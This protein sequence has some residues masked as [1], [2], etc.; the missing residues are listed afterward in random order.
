MASSSAATGVASEDFKLIVSTIEGIQEATQKLRSRINAGDIP[1]FNLVEIRHLDVPGQATRTSLLPD[2]LECLQQCSIKDLRIDGFQ[3]IRSITRSIAALL[4]ATRSTLEAFAFTKIRFNSTSIGELA[5]PLHQH[6]CLRKFML[7]MSYD[8]DMDGRV[9]DHPN[10]ATVNTLLLG[11]QAKFT[12]LSSVFRSLG[13]CLSLRELNL[14][15][16]DGTRRPRPQDDLTNAIK[17]ASLAPNLEYLSIKNCPITHFDS[18]ARDIFQTLRRRENRCAMK[19]FE[20][21]HDDSISKTIRV[22]QE[23]DAQVVSDYSNVI[24]EAGAHAVADFVQNNNTLEFLDLNVK[25][26]HVML[27]IVQALRG[28][29][30]LGTLNLRHVDELLPDNVLKAFTTTLQDNYVLKHVFCA[31]VWQHS[32]IS[33]YLRLNQAGRRHLVSEGNNATRSDW[34]DMIINNKRNY[35][36]VYYF[37]SKNPSL[38]Q[39]MQPLAEKA[40]KMKSKKGGG[41]ATKRRRKLYS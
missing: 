39:L 9:P 30:S 2:L 32:D 21:S 8:W 7:S 3:H 28:N 25:N 4:Q 13:T 34:V 10:D 37:L 35:R 1:Q 20:V 11:I 22:W 6:P 26:A 14:W 23:I 24:D 29:N 31:N 15:F 27:P 33:F 41:G 17:E 16:N 5:A 12:A 19:R 36:F 18:F 38:V 40:K